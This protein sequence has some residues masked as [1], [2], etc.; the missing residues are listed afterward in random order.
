[1]WAIS[2]FYFY[3]SCAALFLQTWAPL[4]I[5]IFYLA[6]DIIFIMRGIVLTD[7]R[8]HALPFGY[9]KWLIILSCAALCLRTCAHLHSPSDFIFISCAALC[10]RTCARLHS[11]SN[12]YTYLN[13]YFH[14]GSE[15]PFLGG[16]PCPQLIWLPHL[17]PCLCRRWR[18]FSDSICHTNSGFHSNKWHVYL[19]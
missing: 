4:L 13:Y 2:Y 10:L 16:T 5:H 17:P 8:T 11:S 15:F 6:W 18:W 3:L 7:L 1:V 12:K 9:N 19:L 14:I